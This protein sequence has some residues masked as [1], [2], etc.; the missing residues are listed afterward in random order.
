MSRRTRA[1]GF[2]VAA[3]CCAGLSA[4]AT[5]GYRGEAAAQLG[6]LRPVV[7]TKADLE[8]GRELRG[9]A[10]LDA[11]SVRRVPTRFV[12]PDALAEPSEAL[13]RAPASRVPAGSYLLASQLRLPGGDR[14]GR[15]RTLDPG[16]HPVEISV[17]GAEALAATGRNPEGARVDVIVTTEPN[18]GGGPGRTYVAVERVELL[19]L[20]QGVGEAAGADAPTFGG[21]WTA[22]LALRRS[23]AV[24]LIQ[25]ESFAR[26]VRLIPS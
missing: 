14:G 26:Q 8:A 18:A 21:G 20:R 13:G 17:T 5:G 22:T 2:G 19:S 3:L 12:S 7:V 4:A 24:R 23:Q 16:R 15:R 25:A 9:R 1:A 10:A 6:P 11:L